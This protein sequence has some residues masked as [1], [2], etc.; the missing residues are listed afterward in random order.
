M[1]VGDKIVCINTG[2]PSC[3]Y[4]TLGKVYIVVDR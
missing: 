4:L 1:V 2:G 3:N